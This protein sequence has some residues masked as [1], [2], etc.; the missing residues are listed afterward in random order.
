MEQAAQD[1]R[2]GNV[3]DLELVEAQQGRLGNDPVGQGR[4]R[5]VAARVRLLPGMY[6]GMGILHEAMEVDAALA[7]DLGSGEEQVHQHAFAA[8][9]VTHQVKPVRSVL[10]DI[11][12]W[13]AAQETR[14]Q[15]G[16]RRGN[17]IIV[18]QAAP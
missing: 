1:H 8:A 13:L 9:D 12:C 4:D 3:V 14:E 18:P 7:A 2:I 6:L 11:V 15:A 10:G 5:V 17:R 16:C